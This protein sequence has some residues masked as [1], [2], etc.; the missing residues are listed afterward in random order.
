M[1]LIINKCCSTVHFSAKKQLKKA[2]LAKKI[3]HTNLETPFFPT[4]QLIA[5][6]MRLPWLKL[7]DE[8]LYA[9]ELSSTMITKLSLPL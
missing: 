2:S 3:T 8:L 9:K 4:N 6:C 5:I 7:Y 1:C